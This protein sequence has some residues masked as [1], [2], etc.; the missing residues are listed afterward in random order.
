[1]ARGKGEMKK[2]MR[3]QKSGDGGLDYKKKN[4]F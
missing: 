4:N 2:F 3:K 1:M